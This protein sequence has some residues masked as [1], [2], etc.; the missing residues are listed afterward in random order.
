MG[1]ARAAEPTLGKILKLG[2]MPCTFVNGDKA[3]V[4]MVLDLDTE[5]VIGKIHRIVDE[6]ADN[7]FKNQES[8][9]KKP[10]EAR[11]TIAYARAN[12]LLLNRLTGST[13]HG[14]RAVT[15]PEERLGIV[16]NIMDQLVV[17]T[18][19]D[20]PPRGRLILIADRTIVEKVQQYNTTHPPLIT[21]V[22]RTSHPL[23]ALQYKA[24]SLYHVTRHPLSCTY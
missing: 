13:P 15:N 4:E 6:D 22:H 3:I 11:Q 20:P 16:Q 10:K 9:K 7:P 8:K 18:M 1:N 5:T 21:I 24:P 19:Q 17:R 14:I 23:V 12:K 2:E